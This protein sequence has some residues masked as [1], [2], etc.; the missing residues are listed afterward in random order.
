MRMHISQEKLTRIDLREACLDF[1]PQTVITRDNVS[2]TIHPLL[3]YR[4][5]DPVRAVY[6]VFDLH[7][8]IEKLVQTTLR[9]EIG[10]L[11]LDDTLASREEI[12][13]AISQKI[14]GMCRNW[15]FELLKVELLEITPTSTI[16]N[17]MHELIRAERV[18]R[19]EIITAHGKRQK[20]SLDSE[21]NLNE[22]VYLAQGEQ[23]KA[24]IMSRGVADSK[25]IIA[26]AEAQ[27][28]KTLGDAL[29]AVDD[30]DPAQYMMALKYV[31]ALSAVASSAGRRDVL[32]P[33]DTDASG[34]LSALC[35][36][37]Q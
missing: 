36:H 19:A 2:L 9:S 1:L 15:G 23:R 4:I 10:D 29:A 30:I 27:A 31:E 22:A 35:G 6:E 24:V 5:S 20:L 8:A 25:L 14:S 26:N 16:L 21:G 34:A 28:L 3:V 37:G 32:L 7:Q 33:L 13:R 12:N 18:R 11:G 17:A